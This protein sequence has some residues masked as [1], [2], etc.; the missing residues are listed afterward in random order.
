MAHTVQSFVETLRADGVEA[1]RKAAEQIR[2]AAEEQAEQLL[3]EAKA[4]ART[5]IEEAEDE[6]RRTLER[7]QTD[8]KLAARDTVAAL[9]DV[10]GQ[11]INRVLTQAVSEAFEDV[12]FLKDLIRQIACAYAEADATGKQTIEVNLPEP[13]RRKLAAWAIDA[14]HQ[15]CDGKKLSVE[16]HGA[17]GS[18]VRVQALR[19]AVKDDARVG[20]RGAFPDCHARIAAT[21]RSDGH[22]TSCC[23][24]CRLPGTSTSRH[25]RRSANSAAR[26]QWGWPI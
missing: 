20:R 17:L 9:R 4:K 13:M 8:L 2:L 19:Q 1:G 23:L 12:D 7:T 6:R 24:P 3:G 5:I 16:L 14:L 18:R 15:G 10:L 26:F 22:L 21:D 25:S 11:A